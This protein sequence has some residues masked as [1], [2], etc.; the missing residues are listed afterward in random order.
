MPR[1][2]IEVRDVNTR[3]RL[4]LIDERAI[5]WSSEQRWGEEFLAEHHCIEALDS[6]EFC[7]ITS[8]VERAQRLDFVFG[9]RVERRTLRQVAVRASVVASRRLDR[10]DDSN[11]C[12]ERG[13]TALD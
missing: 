5:Q 3:E 8:L 6:P 4:S 7:M 9:D 11:P 2:R 13:G 10:R 12:A 1:P